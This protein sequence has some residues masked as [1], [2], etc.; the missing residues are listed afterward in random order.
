MKSWGS[1]WHVISY[2]CERITIPNVSSHTFNLQKLLENNSLW[3][4]ENT[5]GNEIDN[6]KQLILNS[7]ILKFYN[8]EITIEVSYGASMKGLAVV[9]EKDIMAFGTL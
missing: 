7:L 3:W 1:Y 4:F 9:L 5:Y 8:P 6:L 2:K